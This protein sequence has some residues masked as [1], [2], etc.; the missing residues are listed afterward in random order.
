MEDINSSAKSSNHAS[1]LAITITELVALSL[2]G[3]IYFFFPEYFKANSYLQN[4]GL[5]FALGLGFSI[6]GWFLLKTSAANFITRFNGF[7]LIGAILALIYY[8][9][10]LNSPFYPLW[11]I[12]IVASGSN[13]YSSVITMLVIAVFYYSLLLL[14]SSVNPHLHL[15][16][17]IIASAMT[18]GSFGA[19][20]LVGFQANKGSR[21]PS[22]SQSA[23]G[24]DSEKM[25]Q[26]LMMS[27]IADAI[28]GVNK[29]R[30]VILFNDAAEKLTGWDR[31]SAMGI[32]YNNIFK[33][34]DEKDREITEKNDPLMKVFS[35]GS[36]FSTDNFYTMVKDNQKI[37]LS[38]S[39]APTFDSRKQVS[40][41]IAVFHDI[42]EQKAIAR[43]R[44]EFISTA[45]HEM[46][47][48]VATLEAYLSMSL[49]PKMVKLDKKG[50]EFITKAHD[51]AIRLGSLIRD[52]LS[53]TKIDDNRIAESKKV[54]NFSELLLQVFSD[55]KLIADKKKLSFNLHVG[56]KEIK[57]QTVAMP[58]YKVLADPDR[59][60]EVLTNLMDNAI[61][62][63]A[64]GSVDVYLASDKDFL[65]VGI[66]DSGMGISDED[67]KHLFQK[68]YRVDNTMT[69][70]IGGTG[71]G[72]Y[73]A[74]NLIELYG[75][76]IWVESKLNKGSKF[77]FTLP[78]TK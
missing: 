62:F 4:I 11:L 14:L 10:G 78:L 47:S 44:N 3:T 71:L 67:Q 27:F 57:G 21:S 51:A 77:S 43:E 29:N 7:I 15:T 23:N 20:F 65:T 31:K 53:V 64:K 55:M 26:Q 76:R 28:I 75:G 18:L 61:K 52:L 68:F 60:R 69:R 50:T 9:G 49:N 58:A 13:G 35:S 74:R 16:N 5:I 72:L 73:I 40:G 70:E 32:N 59:L 34:K 33:L 41:A 22:L 66:A 48:P 25:S 1:F 45:S 38:I 30:Q 6:I 56:N 8:T 46:R 63:T 39:V 54:F 2:V 24:E 36:S 19:A 12:I 37:S 42:S 17:N